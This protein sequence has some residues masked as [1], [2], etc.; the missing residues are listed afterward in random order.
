[1]VQSPEGIELRRGCVA[2]GQLG[3]IAR[4]LAVEKHIR[5]E[6][7]ADG[8][9]GRPWDALEGSSFPQLSVGALQWPAVEN[10]LSTQ[11]Y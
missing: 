6:Y 1:M 5:M 11:F 8:K 9:G 7:E 2:P 10:L 3:Y 4:P